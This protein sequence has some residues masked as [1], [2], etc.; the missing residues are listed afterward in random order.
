MHTI[1]TTF[2]RLLNPNLAEH[3][4]ATCDLTANFK[5]G[6]TCAGWP[7]RAL[8]LHATTHV[9]AQDV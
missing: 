5:P 8:A 4:R 2:I 3:I 9:E 1:G 7:S 6:T